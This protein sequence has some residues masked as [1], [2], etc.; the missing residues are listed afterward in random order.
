VAFTKYGTIDGCRRKDNQFERRFEDNPGLQN[1]ALEAA[2]GMLNAVLD[3]KFPRP[4]P[5]NSDGTYDQPLIDA[6]EWLAV[7][8]GY[9]RG[10]LYDD[11]EQARAQ[12]NRIVEGINSGL[13][14]LEAQITLDETGLGTP[15]PD[16]DN[17][18]TGSFYINSAGSRYEGDYSTTYL[19]TVGTGG[20]AGTATFSV[21]KDGV[22]L[23]SDTA[24]ALTWITVEYGLQIRFVG[25][26][27]GSFVAGDNWTIV[28]RP[29]EEVSDTSR[30]VSGRLIRA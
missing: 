17:T 5:P 30:I 12:Y 6:N 10:R 29:R 11:E 8:E 4:V 1:G 13:L 7:A 28:C 14:P 21:T 25:N 15:L 19:V 16:T 23:V 20:A 24:T 9:S 22:A 26:A 3:P 27:A 2:A 18:G